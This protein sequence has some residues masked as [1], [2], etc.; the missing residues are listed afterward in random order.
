MPSRLSVI[1]TRTGDKGTTGL[2]DGRRVAKDDPRIEALGTVDELNSFLGLLATRASSLRGDILA[3]QQT[4]F[5]LGGEISLPGQALLQEEKV[6]RLEARIEALNRPLPPL[7]EFILPGGC[8]AAALAHVSRSV[9]RRAERRLVTLAHR[10]PVNPTSL[11]YL[12]RLSDYLFVAART[13]NR[14][15]GVQETLWKKGE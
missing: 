13:L 3:I 6:S 10:E 12:N 9:C 11:K 5:D 15:A 4:L 2:G 7:E 1:V 8:E 14:E